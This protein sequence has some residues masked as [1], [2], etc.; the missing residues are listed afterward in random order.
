MKTLAIVFVLVAACGGKSQPQTTPSGGGEP[1][2]AAQAALP[3]VP[4][5][6]L[7]H[8][9]REQFMEQKVMPAMQPI[10]QNHD[11]K[12]FEKFG[13]A[14][15]HGPGAASGHHEMPN[16]ELPKLD[17]SDMSKFDKRDVEWMEHDVKPAMAKLLQMPEMTRE[18][19]KGFG[20]TSCHTMA[21][22]G[23]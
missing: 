16:A 8:E 11:A 9:Q 14:T 7:N 15:C 19:P 12:K 20:C 5:D 13:C 6:Q 2:P 4:F 23:A 17:F 18:S 21:G 10:F 3:D 22:G 1:G